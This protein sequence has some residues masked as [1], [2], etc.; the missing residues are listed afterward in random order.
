MLA[1][2]L[3]SM[4][5]MSVSAAPAP[6]LINPDALTISG[7]FGLP[8]GQGL[9]TYQRLR[10]GQITL[11]PEAMAGLADDTAAFRS[12]LEQGLTKSL[13]NHGLHAKPDDTDPVVLTI[14]IPALTYKDVADT[15]TGPGST[16][17]E[18]TLIVT[19]TSVDAQLVACVTYSAHGA[20]KALH[21]QKSGGGKRAVG[22]MAA[23]VIG[24]LNPYAINTFTPQSFSNADLENKNLNAGRSVSSNEGVSPGFNA[25]S[26][27][28]FAATNALQLAIY[29]YLFHQLT[30]EAA[31]LGI[32]PQVPSTQV[33]LPQ[34][35]PEASAEPSAGNQIDSDRMS[36]PAQPPSAQPAP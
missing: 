5:G 24:A 10:V 16:L 29:N 14:D 3:V 27:T 31:C 7:R 23:V 8:E 1:S 32:T 20:Y 26:N 13:H 28:L 11:A 36:A 34:N 18:A 25:Q 30:E 2:A 15:A 21:R 35:S 4:A 19:T 33:K 9:I 6:P 12:A 22:I 17:A